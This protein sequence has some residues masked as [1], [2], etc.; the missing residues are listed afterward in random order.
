[1]STSCRAL[2]ATL[3][4]S[5]WHVPASHAARRDSRRLAGLALAL[6]LVAQLLWAPAGREAAA[7]ANG[8]GG[9]EVRG[10]W[11]ALGKQL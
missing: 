3:R 4:C 2:P 8:A 5:A 10:Q 7:V 9:L 11:S 1:M 6:R